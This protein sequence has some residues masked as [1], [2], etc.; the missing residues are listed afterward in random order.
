MNTIT[1]AVKITFDY[2]ILNKVSLHFL[3]FKIKFLL[4]NLMDI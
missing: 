1:V 2:T 4:L 3:V